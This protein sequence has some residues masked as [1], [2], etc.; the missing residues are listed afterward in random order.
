[1]AKKIRAA[2]L[3][4]LEQSGAKVLREKRA[5]E[6]EG[7]SALAEEFRRIVEARAREEAERSEK[8][9]DALQKLVT[10]VERKEVEVPDLRP[11]LQ[12]LAALQKAHLVQR[13]PPSYTFD[14]QRN[15]RDL[16]TRVIARP[17]QETSH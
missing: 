7:L 16:M 15:R 3:T 5:I 2:Q 6:V 11:I 8:I 13:E 4:E 1:M 14:I 9:L 17:E 12:E 10:V